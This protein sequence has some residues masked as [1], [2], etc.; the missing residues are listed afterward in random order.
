MRIDKAMLSVVAAASEDTIRDN[1]RC[2]RI[3]DD[4]TVATNGH[5]LATVENLEKNEGLAIQI[6][7]DDTAAILKTL[8]KTRRGE[9]APEIELSPINGTAVSLAVS[10]PDGKQ[11]IEKP[12]HAGEFPDYKACY[13]SGPVTYRVAF[14]VELLNKLASIAKAAAKTEKDKN[15]SILTLEF[16]DKP[17]KTLKDGGTSPI[18]VRCSSAERFQGLLMPCRSPS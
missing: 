3:E 18:R 2:V 8:P 17:E 15:P 14:N 12:Q 6:G 9:S 4:R 10:N 5:I 11:T 7:A 16:F 13:P 1:L